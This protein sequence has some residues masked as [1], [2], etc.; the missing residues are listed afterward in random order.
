MKRNQADYPVATLCRLLG[1]ST[2]G[3]YAWRSRPPSG[4]TQSDTRLIER[5]RTLHQRSRGFG[6]HQ[7]VLA[8]THRAR[9]FMTGTIVRTFG[10]M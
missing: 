7:P 5:M 8:H 4:R 9:L 10:V 3:Y 2:S 1:V 6:F